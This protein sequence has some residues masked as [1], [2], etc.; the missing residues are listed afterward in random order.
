MREEEEFWEREVKS[1]QDL[2]W[3]IR[4]LEASFPENPS[5][6]SPWGG[7][8]E[9]ESLTIPEYLNAMRRYLDDHRKK[10]ERQGETWPDDLT[11]Q[12]LA[13]LLFGASV[14]E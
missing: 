1:P 2:S 4:Q 3:F 9:W 14:Y 8:C 12:F 11:W 13:D 10:H 6:L 5:E 7:D